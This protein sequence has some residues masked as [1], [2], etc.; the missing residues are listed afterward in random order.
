MRQLTFVRPGLCEWRE[1][2]EPRLEGPLEALVRP[3]VIGRCD[4]DVAYLTGLAPLAAGTPIGHEMIGEVVE[5]GDGVRRFKPGD[6]VVAPAQISCGLCGA[7]RRGST[8]RCESVPFAASYGMGR[9]GDYGCLAADIARIPFADAMLVPLWPGAEPTKLIGAADVGNDSWRTVARPLAERPGARVLVMGGPAA[10]IGIYAA[11]MAAAL[12]AGEVV[13]VDSD[14]HRRSAAEAYGVR[15]QATLEP[16]DL[17]EIVVDAS[18]SEARTLDA[19]RR[20]VG[21]E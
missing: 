21:D 15:T 1:A 2:P 10:S 6:R 3:L 11:G 4:L 17:F 18:A 14:E 9:A 16:G 12:G 19:L 20:D 5:I 13:Y 7:C 8:G